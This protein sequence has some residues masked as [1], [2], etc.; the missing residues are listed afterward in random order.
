[1][2]K[3]ETEQVNQ[4]I[5]GCEEM[6]KESLN[7]INMTLKIDRTEKFYI[8]NVYNDKY[9]ARQFYDVSSVLGFINGIEYAK[10]L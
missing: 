1:M 7:R 9:L 3:N 5:L 8:I 4:H 10:G 6:L 2:F